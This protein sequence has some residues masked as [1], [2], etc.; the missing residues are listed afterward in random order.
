MSK[1]DARIFKHIFKKLYPFYSNKAWM[2][3]PNAEMSCMT[4]LFTFLKAPK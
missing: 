4:T 3:P 2:L 1:I